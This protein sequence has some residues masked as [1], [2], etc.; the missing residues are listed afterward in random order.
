MIKNMMDACVGAIFYYLFGYGFA[1]GSGGNSFIGTDT[2]ALRNNQDYIIWFFNYTFAATTAT[3]V[4]GAV[5]ERCQF[6]AYLVYSSALTAFI[7]PVASHWIWHTDGWMYQLGVL[8]FAGGGAVHGIGGAAALIAATM[9]GPRI[10]KYTVVDGTVVK[11][12]KIPGH[13]LVLSALGGFILWF[14][15]FAFNAASG[16][17]IVGEGAI[18]TGRVAIVTCLGGASGACTLLFYTRIREG[19]WDMMTSLNG[20]LAGMIATCSCCNVIEIWASLIVGPT[21]ALV[22]YLSSYIIEYKLHID[23]PLGAS[24]LHMGA[25]FWGTIMAGF[26]ATPEFAGEGKEGVF[27]GGGKQLGIQIAAVLAYIGWTVATCV[28]LFGSLNYLQLFRV[29]KEEEIAGLD[30]HHHGGYSYVLKKII[31]CF[32]C[33]LLVLFVEN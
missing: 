7:Y 24:P 10:G 15:F 1:Y 6:G 29:T 31:L 3:I 23:D 14:G 19:T 26:L 11:V 8:D 13:N 17:N 22:F 20:L 4:S 2:F 21:G 9:L 25:G 27:Y 32:M 18:I 5:A 33:L 28:L 12:N 16:Y 30:Y